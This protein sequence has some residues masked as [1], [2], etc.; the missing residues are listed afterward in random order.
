MPTRDLTHPVEPRMPTY[1]GDPPVRV[2]PHATHDADGSRV[3]ALE[4][5]TH[6]GTHVDA[7]AHTEPDG[8]TLDAFPVERFD[9]AAR[10]VD[11]RHL[12]AGATIERDDLLDGPDATVDLLVLDTGW[13]A[14]WGTDR[15][16]DHPHL[17][18]AAAEWCAANDLDVGIDAFGVDPTPAESVPAH[19]AL[20]GRDRLIVENLTNLEGLPERFRLRATPLSVADADGAPVRAVATW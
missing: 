10:R 14:H 3:A 16:A 17:A 2:A 5:G 12:G 19:H 1:P 6:T 20:L 15:Y 8:R 4:L 13:H 9:L 7:P 18:P 11:C